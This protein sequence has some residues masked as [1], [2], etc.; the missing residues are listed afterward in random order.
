MTATAFS[1]SSVGMFSAGSRR[2]RSFAV[3][4]RTP[5]AMQAFTTSAAGFAA[6]LMPIISPRPLTDSTP[7][8]P[9]SASNT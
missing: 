1:R 6:G 5:C 3:R 9:V 2:T 7:G 4:Q 8:A